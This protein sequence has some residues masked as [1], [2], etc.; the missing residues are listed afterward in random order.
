MDAIYALGRL[1]ITTARVAAFFLCYDSARAF[2]L[3][4][5]LKG[6]ISLKDI[7]ALCARDTS[8]G[9]ASGYDIDTDHLL[10]LVAEY[11]N[12]IQCKGYYYP[13][14]YPKHIFVEPGQMDIG[15]IDLERFCHV[16]SLPFYMRIW[17]MIGRLRNKERRILTDGLIGTGL[18]S[19]NEVDAAIL[20]AR[21]T[22]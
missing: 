8:A 18:Y 10:R 9:Q 1:G 2:I 5:D 19:R 21:H 17:P 20:S 15:L 11:F 6:Y 14:W 4:K 22:V 16:Q 3:L 12:R 13:D 7:A